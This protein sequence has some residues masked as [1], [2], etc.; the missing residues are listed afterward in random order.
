MCLSPRAEM[1]KAELGFSWTTSQQ[2]EVGIL[3]IQGHTGPYAR[4]LIS[5][6]VTAPGPCASNFGHK[7]P[8]VQH[9]E[10]FLVFCRCHGLISNVAFSR[11][12]SLTCLVFSSEHH[13]Q[14]TDYKVFPLACRF[15]PRHSSA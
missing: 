12:P 8:A 2:A 14:N 1:G 10:V 6:A 11:P 3:S 5:D 9:V 4:T 7:L 15:L 13:I